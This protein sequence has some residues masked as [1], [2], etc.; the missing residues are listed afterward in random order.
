MAEVPQTMDP[1][2]VKVSEELSCELNEVEWQNR[3]RDLADAQE[4]LEREE[5]RKKDVSKQLNADVAVAKNRVS[6]LASVVATR[7]EQREVTVEVK[8]DYDLGVVTRTRTD[9]GEVISEREMTDQER[10]AELDFRDANEVIEDTRAEERA[11]DEAEDEESDT[12][13]DDITEDD[14]DDDA[15]EDLG[16]GN[17]PKETEE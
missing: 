14:L 7:R 5:Q 16:E 15:E 10:Q 9:T 11:A 2:I 13:E 1:K 4:G 17:L 6:K 3:A 8:Y 12:T